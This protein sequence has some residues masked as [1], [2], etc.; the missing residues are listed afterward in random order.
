M[1]VIPNSHSL[2]ARAFAWLLPMAIL[3]TSVT[4]I[5]AALRLPQLA[6]FLTH[7]APMRAQIPAALPR[8]DF[9]PPTS[10]DWGVALVFGPVAALILGVMALAVLLVRRDDLP[11]TPHPVALAA[12]QG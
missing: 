3:G 1:A 9:A 4:A 11:G 5:V 12:P 6:P 7:F 10:I 8:L 2:V